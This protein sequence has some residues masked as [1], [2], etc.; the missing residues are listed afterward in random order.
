MFYVILDLMKIQLIQ[1]RKEEHHVM[2]NKYFYSLWIASV[3]NLDF[4][5]K[6]G[7][8]ADEQKAEL[9]SIIA[10][11]VKMN[12]NSII[13][14]VR[15]CSDALYKS[16]LFPTSEYLTGKQGAPLVDGFDPLQ[17]M[18]DECHARD[19]ELHV[20]LNPYRITTGATAEKPKHDLS[21]LCD[22]HP[23]RLHP[24]YTV[25]Y[26]DGKLYF[27]PGIPEVRKLIVDGIIE[28]VENYDID[29]VHFDDY[30]YPYP[31][32][33]EVDGVS[34]LCEYN[35]KKEYE[36]YGNGLSLGD[37]RREN[38]NVLIKD[39]YDAI[40]AR[41]ENVSFGISPFAIWKNKSAE[42]PEGSDTRGLECATELY[43]DAIAWIKG[44][45]VD[46]ICP[47]IYWTFETSYA[48]FDTLLDWWCGAVEGTGVKLYVGHGVYRVEQ[49]GWE[50]NEI[51]NQ[52]KACKEAENCDGS[53]FFG[54]PNI[55]KNA[56]GIIEKLAELNK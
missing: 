1:L 20:W 18:I 28:L 21:V 22:S 13:F 2:S 15:P 48:R 9:D 49:E 40:K 50:P 17:Y 12:M 44:K 34:V 6:A 7:L 29:G 45:Y 30:F 37:W 43:A 35:D 26:A 51:P 47:Q 52:I 46:Y 32:R 54:Y 42:C 27:N 56:V 53:V 4:P 33:K 24:E 11:A 23:A 10:N 31:A 8:S 14:Q 36:Q 38:V 5:T 16:K 39:C 55:R 19:I 25:A 3:A 41:K